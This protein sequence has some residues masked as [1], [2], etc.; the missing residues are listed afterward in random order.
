MVARLQ[1]R[2]LSRHSWYH[3][4]LPLLYTSLQTIATS[5]VQTPIW[6]MKTSFC[7]KRYGSLYDWSLEREICFKTGFGGPWRNGIPLRIW[8]L[9][10]AM[11]NNTF[12]G[13]SRDHL[14]PHSLCF[15]TAIVAKNWQNS[16]PLLMLP[17]SY[18][19]SEAEFLDVIGT[20]GFLLAI[21]NHLYWRILPPPPPP[22]REK[23]G[24][25]VVSNVKI[26]Y[27]NLK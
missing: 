13:K 24:L 25:K 19:R 22:P 23:S 4:G 21:H 7:Q 8:T 15:L 11:K 1:R 5:W 14:P 10:A 26:V 6:S 12:R 27:G 9:K 18:E 3:K 16:R 20:K 17:K 2:T